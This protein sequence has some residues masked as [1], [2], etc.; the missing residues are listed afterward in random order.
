MSLIKFFAIIVRTIAIPVAL[1][2]VIIGILSYAEVSIPLEGLRKQFVAKASELAGNEVRIDGEVRLAISFYPTL[3]VDDLHI[4]NH[5]GWTADEILSIEEARVQLALMPILSGNLEFLEIS[6]S[7]VQINLEQAK[8]GN[9]NWSSLISPDDKA[10]EDKGKKDDGGMDGSNEQPRAA[11]KK[12]NLWI[13]EFSLADLNINYLDHHLGRKFNSTI[14]N[15]VINTHEKNHLTATLNGT[16]N[17][18]PYFFTA[19]ADLL[20]NIVTRSPWQIKL[21]GKIASSP[22]DL[23]IKLNE[24][25]NKREGSIVFNA[26]NT[27]IGRTLA[28]LGIIEGLDAASDEL[29]LDANIS[30]SN[31]SEII[32]Q[33]EFKA[34]LKNGHLNLHDPA[35]DQLRKIRFSK[36]NFDSNL[37]RPVTFHL[38]GMIDDEP[39]SLSLASNRLR[40]FFSKH[41]KIKLDLH[42]NLVGSNIKLDGNVDLPITRRSFIIDFAVDGKRLDQ[43]NILIKQKLP[44]YGPY[45]LK[46]QLRI[47]SNGFQVNDMKAIVGESDLGGE[48]NIDTSSELATWDFNL[49]SN[50]LQI[51]DFDVEGYSLF[52]R[53]TTESPVNLKKE[54]GHRPRQMLQA[55]E[56]WMGDEFQQL[57]PIKASIRLNAR[58]VVSGDDHLGDGSLHVL[59]TENSIAFK[60]LHLNI[61][62]GRIDGSFRVE[63]T[64][65]G[66]DG[67][68]KLDME[69]FEYG[70]LYRYINPE[71]PAKGL[72]TTKVDL[73]LIGKSLENSLEHA[74]GTLDFA[75]WPENIDA[76]LLNIWSVNLLLA[77]LPELRKEKSVL[78]CGVA[79]LDFED[80]VLS[81]EL[82]FIDSTNVWMRGNMRADFS[83][84]SV[85]L[86]LFPTSKTARLFAL[87]A[88]IRIKG[89]FDELG[90]HIKPFD[91]VRAYLSFIT[92]PLHAPFKRLIGGKVP[93]DASELC[94]QMVDR[95]Y[96]KRL[97]QEIEAT[98]PTWDDVFD[99]D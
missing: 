23:K 73:A 90:A 22:V 43:W 48:L 58:K 38:D 52:N 9:S 72:L 18:I 83:D 35:D 62:G 15:L 30:G 75:L 24:T 95:E 10:P 56:Q 11:M 29:T 33:S 13:E 45:Q 39:V 51:K 44:P 78:N 50:R 74:N 7:S 96:L 41:D 85:S 14:D 94:G 6:A 65:E 77:I 26:K 32:E 25:D 84:E 61:P 12:T 36:A 91:I 37:D 46:G 88:P 19:Y 89:T 28:W 67:H 54:T 34:S 86:A 1:I 99:Y 92:S 21:D 55:K 93:A 82:I 60:S 40:T 71:S 68:L 63:R 27:D 64:D 42:A 79:L 5:P 20:R 76:S 59:M 8:D 4:A 49:V 2:V 66:I 53:V 57:P 69:K 16:T 17:N 70:I 98:Q 3:V 31:L 81:E 87:Q 47:S 97:L 80:G